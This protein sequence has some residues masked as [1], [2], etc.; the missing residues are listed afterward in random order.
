MAEAVA[1]YAQQHPQRHCYLLTDPTL[2]DF[3]PGLGERYAAY[4]GTDAL[5]PVQVPLAPGLIDKS[6]WPTLLALHLQTAAGSALLAMSCEAAMEDWAPQSQRQS[7]GHRVGGWLFSQ[8]PA[9]RI[10][11]HLASRCVQQRV[12]GQRTLVRY[13]DPSVLDMA[14]NVIVQE[15]RDALLGPIDCWFIAGRERQP[16]S[17]ARVHGGIGDAGFPA[18]S[19]GQWLEL[20][21]IRPFNR[22]WARIT[23][24]AKELPG[25][26]LCRQVAQALSRAYGYG[27]ENPEDLEEFAW[28]A[29]SVSPRFDQHPSIARLIR[30]RMADDAFGYVIADLKDEDW[31]VIA[32]EYGEEKME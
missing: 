21:H 30:E 14:W 27:F 8:A 23:A 12:A 4:G 2:R 1:R 6:H 15:Q 20:G 19:R 18:L 7:D 25:P 16:R 26:V 5:A 31:S 10:A 29:F 3:M 24:S 32:M 9:G 28:R 13:Y 11:A 22:A 17:Y